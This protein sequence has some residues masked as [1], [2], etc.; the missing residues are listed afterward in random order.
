MGMFSAGKWNMFFRSIA[1]LEMCV[2][3]SFGE[4]KNKVII[5][6]RKDYEGIS[7]QWVGDLVEFLQKASKSSKEGTPNN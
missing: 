2:C 6:L 5:D 3:V 7:G 1:R 4:I